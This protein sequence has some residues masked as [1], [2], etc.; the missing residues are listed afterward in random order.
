MGDKTNLK[1]YILYACRI[2]FGHIRDMLQKLCRSHYRKSKMN[3]KI[4][5]FDLHIIRQLPL[6]PLYDYFISGLSHKKTV[7]FRY[8]CVEIFHSEKVF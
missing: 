5:M 4:R 3:I 2:E 7:R 6:F 1:A 8:D